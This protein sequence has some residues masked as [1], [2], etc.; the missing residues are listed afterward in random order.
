[1]KEEGME[2]SVLQQAIIDRDEYAVSRF[3]AGLEISGKW[4]LA[5]LIDELLPLSLMQSNLQ[6]GN[7]HSPK[8][9][10]FLR[11][12]A[13]EGCFSR[14]TEFLLAGLLLS[15]MLRT[16]FILARADIRS[17]EERGVEEAVRKMIE[18][19][20]EGNVHN[21][22]FYANIA[23]NDQP[24]NL[25]RALLLRGSR[26]IPD[27]LGHS[28]S[29]FYPIVEDLVLKNHP[30][31][32]TAIFTYIMYLAR[33]SGDEGR[34]SRGREE[35]YTELNL[36]NLLRLASSGNGIVNLH[37]TIT[38]YIVSS[39]DAAS[40]RPGDRSMMWVLAD[41]LRGE[42]VDKERENSVCSYR[43]MST[44]PDTYRSF[45]NAFHI[46]EL[47]EA[48]PVLIGLLERQR[49]RAIDWIFRYYASR[50]NGL[51]NPHY[52]TGLYCA[53]NLYLD[54]RLEEKERRMALEQAVA[55]FADAARGKA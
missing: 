26:N 52:F 14:E 51:W 2:R 29:C 31:R 44:L 34:V 37:H 16:D 4:T 27:T 3:A 15:V 28:V 41:W 21:A 50:C 18:E 5:S 38:F 48:M 54:S 46:N 43:R 1:L 9:Q 35:P 17:G 11:R 40:C 10:L 24:E 22:F 13:L 33:F 12:F 8:V 39:W 23:V 20:D 36:N 47:N 6:Y 49:D 7:F 25:A 42:A 19:L 55:F 30:L 45:N 53:I 32:A